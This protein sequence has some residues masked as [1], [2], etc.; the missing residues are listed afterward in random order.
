MFLRQH[1]TFKFPTLFR[2]VVRHNQ[3]N[4]IFCNLGLQ[5]F[6]RNFAVP[7]A[8][9]EQNRTINFPEIASIT[10]NNNTHSDERNKVWLSSPAYYS[11]GRRHLRCCYQHPAAGSSS[12][13]FA[14]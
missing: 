4:R 13:S 14:E 8:T 1:L 10:R 2:G 5:Y 7:L 11:E 9:E 6:T 3:I 12:F